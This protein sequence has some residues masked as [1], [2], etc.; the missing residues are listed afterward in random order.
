MKEIKNKSIKAQRARIAHDIRDEAI[1]QIALD[2]LHGQERAK[3]DR[4]ERQVKFRQEMKEIFDVEV[5][6]GIDR[7]AIRFED[8]SGEFDLTVPRSVSRG[9]LEAVSDCG[10]CGKKRFSHPIYN[11]KDFKNVVNGTAWGYHECTPPTAAKKPT[12]EE[13]A[14]QLLEELFDLVWYDIKGWD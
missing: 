14:I 12:T 2:V 4:K 7:M 11:R 6:T 1:E 5:G 9:R 13:R 3:E 8:D 10:A